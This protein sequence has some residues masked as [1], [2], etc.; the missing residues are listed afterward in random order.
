MASKRSPRTQLAYDRAEHKR[1]RKLWE[2]RERHLIEAL[3]KANQRNLELQQWK[4]GV[5]F[6][7]QCLLERKGDSE[8]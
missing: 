8:S 1:Q 3:R 4:A 6:A 5:E 7:R 2:E